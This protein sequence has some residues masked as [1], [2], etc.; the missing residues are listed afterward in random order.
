MKKTSLCILA[1]VCVL[2]TLTACSFHSSLS[3]TFS[4]DTGDSVKIELD[5]TDKYSMTPDV[6]FAVSHDGQVQSQG[7]FITA[8]VYAKYTGI[9]ETENVQVLDT[10]SK[11][12]N[13]YIFWCFD[14]KEYN[15]AILVGE[16]N[17]AIL[18]GNMISQE[19]A[20]AC[21]ERLTISAES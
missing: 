21:F 12:G 9:G 3:Y 15:Y 5:T 19:S 14:G 2:V 6:P 16:S 7:T 18:L 13:Q 4:V 20:Q 8:D 17:T 11:D 10:G 1:L